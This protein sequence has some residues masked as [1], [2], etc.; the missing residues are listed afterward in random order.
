VDYVAR[1]VEVPA[2]ELAFYDWSGCT[3]K[4]RRRHAAALPASAEQVEQAAATLADLV[5][6]QWGAE[7]Q[8]RALDDPEPIPV[9]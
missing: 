5:Y 1:Q 8:A 7:A 9:R 2:S 4:A 3:I 6:E